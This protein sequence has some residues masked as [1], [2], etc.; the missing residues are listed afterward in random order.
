MDRIRNEQI[1]GTVKVQ[2]FGHVLRRE[3]GCIGQRMLEM[4]FS[5]DIC[6]HCE[7][8]HTDIV[9]IKAEETGDRARWRQMIRCGDP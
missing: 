4:E 3:G 5:G 8:G 9:G 2:Q 7:R 6:G 1:R